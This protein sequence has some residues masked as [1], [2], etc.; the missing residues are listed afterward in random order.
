MLGRLLYDKLTPHF[1]QTTKPT[2][3]HLHNL[4]GG[5]KKV[6]YQ[7]N[8][9][10]V[11]QS[12]NQYFMYNFLTP[13]LIQNMTSS[14]YASVLREKIT[15]ETTHPMSYYEPEF[16]LPE[17]HGTSH[18]SV[19]AEDGSAVGATSTINQLYDLLTSISATLWL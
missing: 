4:L 5:G 7:P 3:K 15:D 16:Y 18:I 2:S 13:K 17:N 1:W 11:S 6:K 9:F 19:V 8:I 14:S 12:I 10:A